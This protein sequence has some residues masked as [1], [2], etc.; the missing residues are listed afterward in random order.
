[1]TS[2]T[3][4]KFKNYVMF[5]PNDIEIIKKTDYSQLSN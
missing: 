1:M 3:N 2:N 4:V 5:N